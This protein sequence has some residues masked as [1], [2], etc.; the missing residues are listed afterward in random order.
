MHTSRH[1][2]PAAAKRRDRARSILP[3]TNRL[4]ARQ[5][6]DAIRRHNR[7]AVTQSL[8]ALTRGGCACDL[9][10]APDVPDVPDVPCAVC[11]YVEPA[12]PRSEHLLAITRRRDADKLGPVLRWAR[13]HRD[14]EA[15]SLGVDELEAHQATDLVRRLRAD[16]PDGVIGWHAVSHLRF[17]V[18]PRPAWWTQWQQA[19]IASPVATLASMAQW[20]I[21]TGRH[22]ALNQACVAITG[23][24]AVD[25][26]TSSELG[27]HYQPCPTGWVQRYM[28]RWRPLAGVH[29][30]DD[31]AVSVTVSAAPLLTWAITQG[32]VPPD[33]CYRSQRCSS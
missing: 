28:M 22:K 29:D 19:S 3:S 11:D 25:E 24:R 7:R 27:V 12:Y 4:A 16:L 31:W 9:A 20:A 15:A 30:V 6:L 32:W 21:A 18:E 1:L 14:A 17:E 10:D 8:A 33:A 23:Y 5:R 13:Q 26:P 2:D